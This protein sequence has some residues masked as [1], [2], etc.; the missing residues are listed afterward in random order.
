MSGVRY[1][2]RRYYDAG[3]GRVGG[4]DPIEEQGGLH[5][6]GFVGNNSTNRFDVL[7]MD[8][9]D[10]PNTVE[11]RA[12]NSALLA[13]QAALGGRPSTTINQ[14]FWGTEAAPTV[15]GFNG[16]PIRACFQNR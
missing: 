15:G 2:G 10:D 5:L 11:G 16:T 3:K 6:Y 1:Y 12:K 9:F 4:R 13:A 8:E 7:G 14:V